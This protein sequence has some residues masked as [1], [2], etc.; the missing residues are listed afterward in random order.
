M[1][2]KLVLK[3][4]PPASSAST[5]SPQRPGDRDQRARHGV[6]DAQRPRM[7]R[8]TTRPTSSLLFARRCIGLARP[9]DRSW[10]RR[11]GAPEAPAT[12]WNRTPAEAALGLQRTGP[13]GQP[14]SPADSENLRI[15]VTVHIARPDS[16]LLAWMGRT[17][18]TD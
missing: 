16:P 11:T 7:Q 17:C 9:A 3:K 6:G 2:A 8:S 10:S 1:A 4:P 5:W 13:L 12:G 18:L 14:R 15:G